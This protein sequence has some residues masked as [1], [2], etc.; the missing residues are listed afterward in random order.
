MSQTRRSFLATAALAS[1]G[2]VIGLPASSA[3]AA[4]TAVRMSSPG[5]GTAGAIW[6]PLIEA[7]IVKIPPELD[8]SWILGNP[9]QVQLQLT[10]G[11]V[12]VAAYGALGVA[13]IAPRGSDVVIFAPSTNNHGR[14]IVRGDSSFKTPRDLI[15][16]KIATQPESSDTY[17]QARLAGLL[18]GYDLKKDFEVIFGPPTSNLALF[19]RG[20]V[21]AVITIEPTATR[22]IAGGAKEIAKVGDQWQAATNDP[23][24]LLLIGYAGR[25]DWVEQNRVAVDALRDVLIELNRKIKAKPE[26]IAQQHK[27]YGIPDTERAAI[28]LLPGRMADLYAVDWNQA[29]FAN[30]DRQIS[31]SVKAGI[32]PAAPKKPVYLP[33]LAGAGQ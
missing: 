1:A 27:A 21:D 6:K 4:N 15:G 31:E 5:P 20:D 33:A 7:G 3:L 25:R 28:D 12:D 11:A 9:G 16:K 23:A 26:L 22:L 32:L 10:A 8:L 13:E 19:S 24:P 14:W 29:V 2:A 18:H 30:L 17:R